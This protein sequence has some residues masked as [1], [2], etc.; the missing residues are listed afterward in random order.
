MGNGT[1][2]TRPQSKAPIE[3]LPTEKDQESPKIIAN[4][5]KESPKSKVKKMCKENFKILR[6]LRT[7]YSWN[8]IQTYRNKFCLFEIWERRYTSN[9][10]SYTKVCDS[11]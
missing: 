2:C 9:W 6:I 11:I 5:N 8:T 10:F 3:D 4:M 1:C 7:L